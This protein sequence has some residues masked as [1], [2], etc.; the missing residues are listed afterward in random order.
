MHAHQINAYY[1]PLLNEI[2]FPA[3]ILQSPFFDHNAD[4]AINYGGIGAVI[5]HEMTHGFDDKG[6]KFDLEGNLNDWWTQEDT[7]RYSVKAKV[8]SEQFSKYEIEGEKVNGEL[9]LGENIADLGGIT[10]AYSALM[11]K[12]GNNCIPE[13]DGF[14]QKQR[15]FLSWANV[16]KAN[17]RKET[18]LERL[19]VD[20][21][22]PACLRINGV[23]TNLKEF[24]KAFNVKKEDNLYKE[25]NEMAKIW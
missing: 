22:S 2:V 13:I 20:P 11:R 4:D 16:W 5:G 10:I 3:G 21:H 19:I 17:I 23:V 6:K 12:I 18:A 9:T 1:H 25:E 15:F 7:E 24:Y 14:T 8:L